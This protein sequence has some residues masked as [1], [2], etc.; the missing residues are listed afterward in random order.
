MRS[1]NWRVSEK[2]WFIVTSNMSARGIGY[3]KSK[4]AD[5]GKW[6]HRIY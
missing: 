2:K 5:K 1:D 3:F 6:R 4:I